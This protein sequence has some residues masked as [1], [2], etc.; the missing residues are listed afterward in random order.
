MFV[1][2]RGGVCVGA[3]FNRAVGQPC[4]A[5]VPRALYM[6]WQKETDAPLLQIASTNIFF[7]M[8]LRLRLR[9]FRLLK[10]S[11]LAKTT[12]PKSAD[13]LRCQPASNSV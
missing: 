2:L 5:K 8:R 1:Y 13:R 3:V 10:L 6:F 4:F 9:P 7:S 12:Q 11:S